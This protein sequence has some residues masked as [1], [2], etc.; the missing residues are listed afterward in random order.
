[1]GQEKG[2]ALRRARA[3]HCDILRLR[4]GSGEREVERSRPRPRV[5]PAQEEDCWA[6]QGRR[7][8]NGGPFF[9]AP[10]LKFGSLRGGEILSEGV[11]GKMYA[12]VRVKKSKVFRAQ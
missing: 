7:E 9:A 1:V 5:P 8:T 12:R 3:R 10:A 11:K 4:T 2:G 6:G